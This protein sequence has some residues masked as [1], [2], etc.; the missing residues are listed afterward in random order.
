MSADARHWVR[1]IVDKLIGLCV[2]YNCAARIIRSGMVTHFGRCRGQ[3]T[4]AHHRCRVSSARQIPFLILR[5]SQR[6]LGGAMPFVLS[7]LKVVHVGSRDDAVI[8]PFKEVIEPCEHQFID[9]AIGHW[10]NSFEP[11]AHWTVRTS[12]SQMLPWADHYAL[13]IPRQL[14][15]TL[16]A[17]SVKVSQGATKESIVPAFKREHWYVDFAVS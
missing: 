7:H 1:W 10:T 16:G 4:V 12:P 14:I 2:R 5:F 13:I 15:G 8:F 6:P 3:Y 11:W 17:H 9:G